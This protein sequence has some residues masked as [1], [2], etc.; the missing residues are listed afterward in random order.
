MKPTLKKVEPRDGGGSNGQNEGG[1]E[2]E[3]INAN[4]VIRA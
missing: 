1:E 4:D 3:R 2:G